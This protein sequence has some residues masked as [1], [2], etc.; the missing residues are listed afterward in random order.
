MIFYPFLGNFTKN[1]AI[2]SRLWVKRQRNPNFFVGTI[3]NYID[4]KNEMAV[5]MFLKFDNID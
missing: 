5:S 1:I 3:L 4:E 2:P